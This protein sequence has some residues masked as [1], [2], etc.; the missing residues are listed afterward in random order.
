M[1][2]K[3]PLKLFIYFSVFLHL[4]GGALYYYY[5]NPDF[6][7][8]TKKEESPVSEDIVSSVKDST[9]KEIFVDSQKPERAKQLLLEIPIKEPSPPL[10]TEIEPIEIKSPSTDSLIEKS[11]FEEV[12]SEVS[13]TKEEQPQK[14]NKNVKIFFGS[15]TSKSST[16]KPTTVPT[17]PNLSDEVSFAGNKIDSPS[18]AET[19][20]SDNEKVNITISPEKAASS[21]TQKETDLLSEETASLDIKKTDATT[22]PEEAVLLETQEKDLN[23]DLEDTPL[24]NEESDPS[25]EELTTSD[26]P[27]ESLQKETPLSNTK[28]VGLPVEDKLL[29]SK[30]IEEPLSEEIVSPETEKTDT[31]IPSEEAVPSETQTKELDLDSEDI[32]LDNEESD[33]VL[34]ELTIP[35]TSTESPQKETNTNE[36]QSPKKKTSFSFQKFLDLKQRSGNPGLTYPSK[37][38]QIK[39]QGSLSLIF[40]VTTG[41][42]V[43]KIQIEAS[44]GHR[45]LDNSVVQTLARYKFLPNQEG[46]VRHKVDFKLKGEKVEFL[47]LR[48][49]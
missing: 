33:P 36:I 49:K 19:V 38:R 5:K 20:S 23:L 13:K 15:D 43:E 25:I 6:S 10:E 48:G 11:S 14:K 44:S 7:F 12:D 17:A 8:F 28:Q 9:A 21:E 47:R 18:P 1:K 35:D 32:P 4:L 16:E 27:T 30:K 39:A 45:E 41:G 37:A 24:D 3:T 34:E 2:I 46:W 42:L 31:T 26:T 40:Y 29:N 22:P